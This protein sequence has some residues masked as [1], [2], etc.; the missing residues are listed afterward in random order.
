LV[1]WP[2]RRLS[3]KKSSSF[4]RTSAPAWQLIR[5][6]EDEYD[7]DAEASWVAEIERRSAEVEAGTASTMT[8][9]EYR[10]HVRARRAA[11]SP[12]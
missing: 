7:A 12:R 8:L 1:S 4:R 2:P 3:W 9:D 10:A 6:L 5:S 11:R